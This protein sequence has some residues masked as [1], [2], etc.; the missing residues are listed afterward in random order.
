MHVGMLTAPFSKDGLD[1][2]VKFASEVGFAALE[3]ACQ[4]G[5]KHLDLDRDDPMQVADIVRSAGLEISSLTCHIDITAADPE[6]RQANRD[7][8]RKALAACAAMKVDLLGCITGLPPEGKTREET[9]QQDVSPFFNELCRDAANHGIRVA[10]ENWFAT[11]IPHLGYWD[12]I[13]ET[14]PA[15]NFGLNFDPSHLAWMGI[16]YLYAIEKFA[17]RIFYTHAKDVAINEH[18][19]RYRG[20]QDMSHWRYVIPG[21]GI[22]DWGT[23]IARLRDNGYD[24]VLS[25]EHE[26]RAFGREEGFVKGLRHLKQFC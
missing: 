7:H 8:L 2:V 21:Y 13:F 23:Y 26:D 11:N 9:I 3:I 5:C 15:D 16:D 25:I 6:K 17:S 18:V 19:L 10:V 14:C 22:I 1:T 24:G 12:M 20:N 4:P